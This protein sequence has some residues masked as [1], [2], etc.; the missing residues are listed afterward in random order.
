MVYGELGQ[1]PLEVQAK[2]RM[3]NI[4][5]KL[6]NINYKFKFSN[7]MYKFLYE[8]YMEGTYK[9]PFLSTVETVLNGI[10]L[11]GMLQHQFGLN[12]VYLH[13]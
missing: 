3:L 8:M 7:T 13:S 5:F 10:G 1:F 4:W 12:K 11:S 2:C 9:S 6:V